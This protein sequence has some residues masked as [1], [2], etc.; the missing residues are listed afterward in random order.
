MVL[1]LPGLLFTTGLLLI[2]S[3]VLGF[4]VVP[5]PG[6]QSF[7]V[8]FLVGLIASVMALFV[9][10][11]IM[12]YLIGSGKG[13]KEAIAR[14]GNPDGFDYLAKIRS[15][16]VKLSGAQ[17]LVI[18]ITLVPAILGGGTA[19]LSGSWISPQVHMW[20]AIIAVVANFWL[21]PKEYRIV[22]ENGAMVHRLETLL[23]EKLKAEKGPGDG[24][25]EAGKDSEDNPSDR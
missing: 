18:G 9:H 1:F 7:V 6:S 4:W 16:K 11:M 3:M 25:S 8:H 23:T 14:Y 19:S 12:F 22:K 13:M 5:G 21:F 2:A 20:S 10:A 17:T 15:Y 24:T